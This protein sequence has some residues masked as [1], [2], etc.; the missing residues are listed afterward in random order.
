[1][2][3]RWKEHRSARGGSMWTRLH[4]PVRV[5]RQF[6][7]VPARFHLGME[8]QVTAQL[9]PKYGVNNVRGAEFSQPREFTLHDLDRLTGFLGHH[10][11]RDYRK[12]A[13]L[14]EQ[15]LLPASPPPQAVDSTCGESALLR[16][17]ASNLQAASSTERSKLRKRKASKMRPV[18]D[19]GHDRCF[20]CGEF[21]HWKNEC[22]N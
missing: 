5:M 22:P 11:N 6:N 19:R 18:R 7:R 20:K 3:R 10:N 4:K 14:I 15:F 2:R 13:K 1:M 21:G 9:M 17:G 8:S 16:D 12:T